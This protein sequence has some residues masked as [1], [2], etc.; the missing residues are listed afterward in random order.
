MA[1]W[2]FSR[3]RSPNYRDHYSRESRGSRYRS[4]SRS[5]G[6]GRRR[7]GKVRNTH[8]PQW[9]TPVTTQPKKKQVFVGWWNRYKPVDGTNRNYFCWQLATCPLN[10]AMLFLGLFKFNLN[11]KNKVQLWCI[12][13]LMIDSLFHFVGNVTHVQQTQ[14]YWK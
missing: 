6:Y 13:Q 7:R 9:Y 5:P 1:V 4:R 2:F 11:W 12:D 10:V 14:T 3:G 8:N